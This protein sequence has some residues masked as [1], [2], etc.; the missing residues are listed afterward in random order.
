[1]YYIKIFSLCFGIILFTNCAASADNLSLSTVIENPLGFKSNFQNWWDEI[2]QQYPNPINDNT[3]TSMFNGEQA[4]YHQYEL[5]GLSFSI[6]ADKVTN[7]SIT[8]SAIKLQCGLKVGDKI[9]A[10][11][12]YLLNKANN[13]DKLVIFLMNDTFSMRIDFNEFDKKKDS[14]KD[15]IY[16]VFQLDGIYNL[17]FKYANGIVTMIEWF[18]SPE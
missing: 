13:K 3:G 8:S 9:D 14:L 1:M 11:I 15:A 16:I 2:K 4:V 6:I 17:K 5:N 10:V 7:I 12:S 18:R